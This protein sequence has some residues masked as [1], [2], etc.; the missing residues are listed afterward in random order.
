MT[1]DS[2]DALVERATAVRERLFVALEALDRKRHALTAPVAAVEH[3]IAVA[4]RGAGPAFLASGVLLAL[5]TGVGMAVRARRQR[6]QRA[7]WS[8]VAR[9]VG[10]AIAVLLVAEAARGAVARLNG[11]VRLPRLT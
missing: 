2:A 3:T 5:G 1:P 4:A 6:A 8:A 10:A 11:R 9:Q 7:R